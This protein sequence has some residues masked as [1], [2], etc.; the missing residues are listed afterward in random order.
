MKMNLRERIKRRISG[1]GRS[2]FDPGY[3]G[4]IV[5]TPTSNNLYIPEDTSPA[6]INGASHDALYMDEAA[7]IY[8]EAMIRA[9]NNLREMRLWYSSEIK[10]LPWERKKRIN[11]ENSYGI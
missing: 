11:K 10:E 9:I 7:V 5:T 8:E 6:N 4:R 1:D 3:I 2:F